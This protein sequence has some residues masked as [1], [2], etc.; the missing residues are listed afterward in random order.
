MWVILKVG[1]E[2]EAIKK[3]G[4]LLLLFKYVTQETLLRGIKIEKNIF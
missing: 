4:A 1:Q 2:K 3:R